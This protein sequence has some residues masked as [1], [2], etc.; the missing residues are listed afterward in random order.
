MLWAHLEKA[1][2]GAGVW[3][4]DAKMKVFQWVKWIWC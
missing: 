4:M 2:M 1:Y 3:V